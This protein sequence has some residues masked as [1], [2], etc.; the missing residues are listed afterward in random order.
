M[1]LSNN[2]YRIVFRTYHVNGPARFSRRRQRQRSRGIEAEA[3]KQKQRQRNRGRGS[4]AQ[5]IGWA[6]G[7]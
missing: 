3:E 2:D 4:E 6:I 7:S 1:D 5:T